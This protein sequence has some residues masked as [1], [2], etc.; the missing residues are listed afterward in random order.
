MSFSP[1]TASMFVSLGKILNL[2]L[3]HYWS[4][5]ICVGCRECY[6]ISADGCALDQ[7]QIFLGKAKWLWWFPDF[8]GKIEQHFTVL[9][10]SKTN[11]TDGTRILLLVRVLWD[12]ISKLYWQ[13]WHSFF[14]NKYTWNL[15]QF[16]SHWNN[17][18]KLYVQF[19][20]HQCQW[21]CEVCIHYDV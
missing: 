8:G 11:F 17:V 10:F 9:W 1:T 5:C 16:L 15:L 12:M 19:L 7:P 4:Q 20:W 21:R 14:K 13:L 6:N 3:L 18:E 2:N